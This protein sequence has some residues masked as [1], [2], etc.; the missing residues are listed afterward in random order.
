MPPVATVERR[1]PQR[2]PAGP[3]PSASIRPGPPSVSC[4]TRFSRHSRACQSSK[5]ALPSVGA[6]LLHPLPEGR[7]RQ[8]KL[9]GDRATH[10]PSSRTRRAAPLLVLLGELPP[11]APQCGVRH[12]GHLTRLSECPPNRIKPTSKSATVVFRHGAA[13]S[14]VRRFTYHTGTTSLDQAADTAYAPRE[15][16]LGRL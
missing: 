11:L 5:L 3:S 10:L 6:R 14:L 16:V 1:P 13:S 2:A 7:L 4:N 9:A 15:G 12:R 8:I